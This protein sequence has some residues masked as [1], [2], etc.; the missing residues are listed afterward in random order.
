TPGAYAAYTFTPR[1]TGM[2]AGRS[3][4]IKIDIPSGGESLLTGAGI[5][6][7]PVASPLLGQGDR[8]PRPQAGGSLYADLAYA[9]NFSDFKPAVV[10]LRVPRDN[11]L[12]AASLDVLID[13]KVPAGL[14]TGNLTIKLTSDA[15]GL[16]LP[17]KYSNSV[18]AP[19]L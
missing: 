14:Q 8:A 12:S 6:Q 15:N 7:V 10:P 13:G 18:K 1:D 5:N 17:N 11:L 4:R 2:A 16:L 9:P 3:S 19:A